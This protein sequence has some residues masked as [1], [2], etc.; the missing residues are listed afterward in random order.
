VIEGGS[1]I[2]VTRTVTAGVAKGGISGGTYAPPGTAT[3]TAGVL[4]GIPTDP[5]F[6]L[7][8]GTFSL[9]NVTVTGGGSVA[10]FPRFDAPDYIQ[11]VNDA[12]VLSGLQHGGA[13][14]LTR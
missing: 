1:L 13:M 4:S 6:A 5:G 2:N 10:S 8:G 3:L 11:S 12:A 9:A 7:G 14:R